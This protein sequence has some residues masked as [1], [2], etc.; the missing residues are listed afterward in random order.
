M[1]DHLS[2]PHGKAFVFIFTVVVVT[3]ASWLQERVSRTDGLAR[4]SLV[5]TETGAYV[6]G[7]FV[8]SAIQGGRAQ[9]MRCLDVKQY[10][11][12]MPVSLAFLAGNFLTYTAVQGL[13]ASQFFLLSQLRVALTAVILW[14]WKGVH[15][16]AAEWIALMQLCVG[17]MLLVHL[18][19]ASGS[20]SVGYADGVHASIE[21]LA[22]E[23]HAMC[24]RRCYPWQPRMEMCWDSKKAAREA[25]Q[26]AASAAAELEGQ[27]DFQDDS[28]QDFQDLQQSL[29]AFVGCLLSS[30]F[31]FI[32]MEAQFKARKSES[33]AVKL[34]Q[35][36]MCGAA[37]TLCLRVYSSG[38]LSF[39]GLFD[40]WTVGV[41]FFWALCVAR[42]VMCSVIIIVFDSV[43]KGIADIT[44]MICVC[45]LQVVVDNA[46]MDVNRAGLQLMLVLSIA[47]Y[48]SARRLRTDAEAIRQ[49]SKE[50]TI[51][52][53][54]LSEGACKCK[55]QAD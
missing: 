29:L 3:L 8:V 55:L 9:A 34:H 10:V 4:E 14:V 46:E 41:V 24:P 40:G 27:L 17:L 48:L 51:N 42:G 49:S 30:A 20:P 45:V 5:L 25:I 33:M 18:N 31:A 52:H 53:H 32:Y 54:R 19:L 35:L 13:G 47:V 26:M 36:N 38:S 15:Q 37:T 6:F 21:L 44:A 1:R 16:S 11:R 39:A 2:R 50:S 43:V 12:F 22:P 7:G 23:R 28:G